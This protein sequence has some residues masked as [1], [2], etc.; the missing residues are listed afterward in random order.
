MGARLSRPGGRGAESPSHVTIAEV[1]QTLI[2]KEKDI[3]YKQVKKYGLNLLS[4][5]MHCNEILYLFFGT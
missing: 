4:K 1:R 3:N 5:M 2:M